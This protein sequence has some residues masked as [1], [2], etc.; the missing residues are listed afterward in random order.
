MSGAERL[1][2]RVAALSGRGPL[3]GLR[4]RDALRARFL[5]AELIAK[6]MADREDPRD[7]RSGGRK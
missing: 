1:L 5:L 2:L 4:D 7:L 3:E 6:P